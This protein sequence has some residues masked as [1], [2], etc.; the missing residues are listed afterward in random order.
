[1]NGEKGSFGCGDNVGAG[2]DTTTAA[3]ALARTAR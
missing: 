3:S 1:V 2:C